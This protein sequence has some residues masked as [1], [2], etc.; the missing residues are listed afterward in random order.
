LV[1]AT[2]LTI[3]L[4]LTQYFH[5]SDSHRY[6]LLFVSYVIFAANELVF[7]WL[8]NQFS[9]FHMLID[10]IVI[11]VAILGLASVEMKLS[12][13]S[14]QF[15]FHYALFYIAL[16]ATTVLALIDSTKS[17]R[18]GMVLIGLV[19]VFVIVVLI[20]EKSRSIIIGLST[21]TLWCAA[22]L[23]HFFD[24]EEIGNLLVLFF[25]CLIAI[26]AESHILSANKKVVNENILL[27]KFRNVV[28][29]MLNS[30]SA[31]TDY[32]TSI[33]NTLQR[34]LET[35]SQAFAVQS[36][37]L[38]VAE[39][40]GEEKVLKYS[41]SL[42]LFYPLEPQDEFV[43]T[44]PQLIKDHLEKSYY[45]LGEGIVGTVAQTGKPL[46][47]DAVSNMGRMIDLGL[48]THVIKSILAVPLS[49]GNELFGVIVIQNNNEKSFFSDNDV[50]LL[51]ALADQ[52]GISISSVRMYLELGR[53][54]R[55]RQ[56]ANIAM[57]IQ[58]Q[59]LPKSVPVLEHLRISPFIE[60]A[61][62][63][64]GDYYD[65]VKHDDHTLGIV[66]GDVSG[67]GVPAGMM[68][69]IAK[70]IIQIVTREERNTKEI[71]SR[72]SREIYSNMQAGQF[73]TLN[74][75]I[76]DDV[77]RMITFSG[78]GHEHVLWF[79]GG[80][81][82]TDKIKAGGLAAGL[83]EDSSQYIQQQEL[84]CDKGDVIV[85]Y[86]DGVTEARNDASE[87]FTLRRLISSVESY[88]Y[89]ADPEKI[90]DNILKDVRE[91]VAGFEQYDDI[92]LLVL[93]VQ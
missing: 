92:T 69:A 7:L 80:S 46:A 3:L 28:L 74:Y 43:F 76:W 13:I 20:Q 16:F 41:G 40:R 12:S 11:S 79:H 89:L 39:Q 47:L 72:F 48:K 50:L 21:M 8:G 42:G 67:K 81:G 32:L 87:I 70:A 82:R 58:K 24:A 49:I 71:I 88:A 37:G 63:V 36:A 22:H 15:L 84:R 31:S 38:Y 65:F 23:A 68:M 6:R 10:C 55:L 86:T 51:Q 85:L 83:V 19:A 60:P 29:G 44:K 53:T 2:V 14:G 4:L 18:L 66:I 57:R 78:A 73:M 59:L 1:S 61:K 30:I 90:R 75:L 9:Y 5:F 64:G 35:I 77:S 17:E 56:E 45:P 25:F 93:T 34:I 62:E 54:T 91:F 52:C 26:L 33:D 27:S